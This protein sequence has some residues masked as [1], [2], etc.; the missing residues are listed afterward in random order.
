MNRKIIPLV[1]VFGL[2]SFATGAGA[3]SLLLGP[4]GEFRTSY[5]GSSLEYDPAEGCHKPTR[6][7]TDDRFS[8]DMYRNEAERYLSCLEGAA[9]S[10]L[11]YVRLVVQ[12]GYE[13][14]VQDFL[15]EVERGF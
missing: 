4:K 5:I 15:D 12:D 1:V 9:N 10:D 11:G 6:P 7:F 14:A 8:W 3:Q 13:K 2:V